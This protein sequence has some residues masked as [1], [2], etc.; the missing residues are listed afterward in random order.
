MKR[1]MTRGSEWKLI[2]LFTLPI[3]AGNLLQ[4]LYNTADNVIVGNF[5]SESAFSG[6][7]VCAALTFLFLSFAM[8]ISAGV[9]VVTSQLFGARQ[10][11]RLQLAVDT[12][13]LLLAGLGVVITVAG[14]A[15]TPFLLETVLSVPRGDILDSAVSYMRIYCLGLP[16]QFIYNCIS[17]VLRGVGDSKAS[18][19]FLFITAVLNIILDLAAVLLLNLGVVGTAWA[20]VVSQLVCVI[21]SYIYLRRRFPFTRAAEHFDAGI[22]KTVLKIGL[23][24]AVQQS[25]VSLGAV[26]MQRLV[27]GFDNDAVIAAFGAGNRINSFVFVP[28]I[29]FQSGL[30]NFT[31]Q[32]VGA[33]R[34]DRVRRGY[35]ATLGMG[36]LATVVI[37]V[38]MYVFSGRTVALFG[39]SGESLNVGS[40]MIRFHA[41]W[42]WF[43]SL[44][45]LLG[46]VLQGAGDTLLQ[47]AATLTALVVRVALGYLSVRFGMLGYA[48]AWATT[49]IGWAAAALI[50][51]VRYFTG[52]WRNKSVV[53]KTGAG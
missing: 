41:V 30:A 34:L 43:F 11:E 33:G 4:Q 45:M 6:V 8:G 18:L 39:L 2:L 14:W 52:G 37:C 23:P 31:G 49:P 48:A 7:A 13:L 27:N 40:E 28:I 1:D 42:Y 17:F 10:D 20:T 15:L 44:Y 25:I 26:A 32:N 5:V 38:L 53:K 12:S 36:L 47:S 3:M 24:T 51:N 50:T 46:G 29:G 19:Y 21:I 9:G 22:C 16:F 35:H